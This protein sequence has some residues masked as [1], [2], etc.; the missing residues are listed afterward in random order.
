[1]QQRVKISQIPCLDCRDRHRDSTVQTGPPPRSARTAAPLRGPRARRAGG[2]RRTP[3]RGTVGGVSLLTRYLFLAAGRKGRRSW[4]ARIARRPARAAFLEGKR[5]KQSVETGRTNSVCD[6]AMRTAPGHEVEP[7]GDGCR[8][9]SRVPEGHPQRGASQPRVD[10]RDQA[11]RPESQPHERFW[12]AIPPAMMRRWG[13]SFP[14]PIRGG[15]KRQAAKSEGPSREV[16]FAARR[17]RPTNA[18]V[19]WGT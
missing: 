12:S 10:G 3:V 18:L 13:N 15:R 14:H 17:W 9:K 16:R 7:P 8:A 6:G 4:R 19:P 5:P 11:G 1:M 2:E